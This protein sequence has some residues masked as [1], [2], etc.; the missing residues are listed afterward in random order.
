MHSVRRVCLSTLLLAAFGCGD[1][2][3]GADVTRAEGLCA[4]EQR[5]DTF[6]AGLSRA[7]PSGAFEVT[8][9]EAMP[10]PPDRGLNRWV[11]EVKDRTGALVD[12]AE[13]RLRPWMPD[14][15]HG[16]NPPHLF[17]TATGVAGQYQITDMDLFMSGLWQFTV[18]VER[19]ADSDELVFSFCIEG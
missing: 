8:F 11:L 15:G 2:Q 9:V 7:S 5:A 3:E 17:P 16:S 18:R 14:H 19:G 13:V 12:G 6:V 4:Q 10:A 1:S